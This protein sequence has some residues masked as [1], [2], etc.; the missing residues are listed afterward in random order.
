MKIE[1][2]K[3]DI[4]CNFFH[5]DGSL[6]DFYTMTL[7]LGHSADII[8]ANDCKGLAQ[9]SEKRLECIHKLMRRFKERL[10]RKT[11]LADC[12]TDTFARLFLQSSPVME[13]ETLAETIE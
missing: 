3:I 7:L 9:L 4:L 10:S 1:I 11:K 5:K 12:V 2:Y 6:Q 8:E 13:P